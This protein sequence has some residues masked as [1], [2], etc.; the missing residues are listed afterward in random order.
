MRRAV[1]ATDAPIRV[2]AEGGFSSSLEQVMIG[3][4][5]TM[6]SEVLYLVHTPIHVYLS[7][8]TR[9][10]RVGATVGSLKY[11]LNAILS[12]YATQVNDSMHA[13]QAS[14]EIEQ[15]TVWPFI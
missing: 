11:V 7:C 12:I 9:Y 2:L 1:V 14:A 13:R 5:P 15:V 6:P 3:S 8:R 10:A 4:T